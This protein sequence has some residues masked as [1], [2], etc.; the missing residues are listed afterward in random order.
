MLL[1]KVLAN[2]MMANK[3]G[4]VNQPHSDKTWKVATTKRNKL[5]MSAMSWGLPLCNILSLS[6]NSR[7]G[8][9]VLAQRGDHNQQMVV[10]KYENLHVE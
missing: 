8:Q 6:G 2:V 1:D 7:I 3:I 4:T 10:L 9:R 5:I